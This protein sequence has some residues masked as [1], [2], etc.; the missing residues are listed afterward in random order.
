MK[1]NLGCGFNKMPGY[2]NVDKEAMCEPDQVVDM[3]KL[4]W[5]W[6]DNSV[7][8]IVAS[9]SLEHVGATSELYLGIIKEMYRVCKPG[10]LI[11]IA[12][13]HPRHDNFMFDPTHV[14]PI[15][16]QG[17]AMFDQTRNIAD[18]ERG[19]QETK[20]GLYMGVDL[21]LVQIGFDLEEP[22]NS[23]IQPN[24]PS[25]AQ[26]KEIERLMRQNNNI[27]YQIRIL[28][29]AVK[30]ARGEGWKPKPKINTN[31]TL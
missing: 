14:R 4:P 21:E 16:P 29:R 13:P 22:W 27:C 11:K 18:F 20:L 24:G 26:A 12:V 15:T 3:E 2:V 17:L 6:P 5:P 19:G 8:E 30:P 28:L 23:Q 31:M 10:A 25:E 1:I 7:E 9:H